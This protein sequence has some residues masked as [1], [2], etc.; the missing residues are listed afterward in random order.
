MPPTL[1]LSPPDQVMIVTSGGA[2]ITLS[3]IPGVGGITL[4]A[5]DGAK[6]A[7]TPL[8]L[9]IS[10]GHGASIKLTGPMVSVNDGALDVI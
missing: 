3:D 7:M 5:A 1:L 10:N 8:S 6:I 4:E 9:E 2:S